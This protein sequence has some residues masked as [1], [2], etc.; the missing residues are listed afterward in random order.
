MLHTDFTS[1]KTF[2]DVLASVKREITA[3]CEAI[4]AKVKN[5]WFVPSPFAQM[6]IGKTKYKNFGIHGTGIATA[7][8]SLA[9]VKKYVFDEKSVS[10]EDMLAAVDAN[11]ENAPELLD[12]LRNE[13]PKMGPPICTQ[14]PLRAR[15]TV[16]AVSGEQVQALRCS[17]S[18]TQTISARLPTE[19]SAASPSVPTSPQASLQRPQVPFRL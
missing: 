17:T 15:R 2:D 4:M 14:M 3:E 10:A 1:C 9:A 12:K 8:D 7:S 5:L 11:F 19:E 16:R 6:L 13:A 18:G